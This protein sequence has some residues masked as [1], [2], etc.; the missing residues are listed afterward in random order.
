MSPTHLHLDCPS[1]ISGDMF[2]AALL[3]LGVPLATFQE[4]IQTLGLPEKIT[5]QT[6]RGVRGGIAGTRFLVINFLFS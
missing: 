4:A 6:E 3:D 1:G 2:A 5:L